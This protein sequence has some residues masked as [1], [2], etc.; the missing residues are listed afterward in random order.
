[1]ATA[2]MSNLGSP[3]GKRERRHVMRHQP[4]PPAF[5]DK[6][7]APLLLLAVAESKLCCKSRYI[8]PEAQ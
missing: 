5:R 2:A 6:S 4:T 3:S 7:R 8:L 1:M